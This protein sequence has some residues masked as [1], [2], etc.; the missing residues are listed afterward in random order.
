M[1]YRL[2]SSSRAQLPAYSY[3]DLQH[4]VHRRDALRH[5]PQ[6]VHRR[7]HVALERSLDANVLLRRETCQFDQQY[8]VI[9][10]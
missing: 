9:R 4:L 7:R 8:M 2:W 6:A 3:L 1:K 10:A 5:V